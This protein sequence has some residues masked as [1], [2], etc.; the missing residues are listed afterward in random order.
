[1]WLLH[2][3]N[4]HMDGTEGVCLAHLSDPNLSHIVYPVVILDC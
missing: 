2:F 3:Q 4:Y 1:M